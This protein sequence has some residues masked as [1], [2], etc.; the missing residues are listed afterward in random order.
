MPDEKEQEA[1]SPVELVDQPPEWGKPETAP[2][3]GHTLELKEFDNRTRARW[4]ELEKKHDLERLG[5]EYMFDITPKVRALAGNFS[6]V[7]GFSE[8]LPG[9][10]RDE[11][12][13]V[14]LQRKKLA[15]L[16]AKLD[17]MTQNM[18]DW[19]DEDEAKALALADRIDEAKTAL[20]AM[21]QDTMHTTLGKSQEYGERIQ[22]F[23][24]A[25]DCA[26]LEL[27]WL[28]VKLQGEERPFEDFEADATSS[29]YDAAERVVDAGNAGYRRLQSRAERRAALN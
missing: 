15:S 23:H 13:R 4:L 12:Q 17:A 27:C 5:K 24:E 9:I 19:S 6:S 10:K 3:C 28:L 16:G 25:K 14:T 7:L 22:V 20:E 18:A 11:P 1:P 21:E 26:Q 29:D 2:V 8:D